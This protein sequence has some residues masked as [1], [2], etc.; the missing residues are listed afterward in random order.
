MA[1]RVGFEPTV[2][3]GTLDFESSTFDLSDTSPQSIIKHF[4]L[5]QNGAFR[6]KKPASLQ[7]TLLA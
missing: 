4:Q 3:Y 1:E 7:R 5:P 2:P 6:E